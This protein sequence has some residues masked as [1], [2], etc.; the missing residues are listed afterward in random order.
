MRKKAKNKI[1]AAMFAACI[2]L[3]VSGCYTAVAHPIRT[4]V[5]EIGCMGWLTVFGY[6][7]G[8]FKMEGRR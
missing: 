3:M 8:F 1:L 7:N 5:V 2:V 6:A 4:L